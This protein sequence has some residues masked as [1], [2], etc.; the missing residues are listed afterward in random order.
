MESHTKV[1]NAD[2]LIL[3]GNHVNSKK[4]YLNFSFACAGFRM[5]LRTT[6][7]DRKSTFSDFSFEFNPFKLMHTTKEHDGTIGTTY[8]D[9]A[10]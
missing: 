3:K 1:S 9:I 2:K 6:V 8:H 7:C 10:S 5:V 4:R